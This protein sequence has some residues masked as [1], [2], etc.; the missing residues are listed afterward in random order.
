VLKYEPFLRAVRLCKSHLC[1]IAST[2][3]VRSPNLGQTEFLVVTEVKSAT[4]GFSLGC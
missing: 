1:A 2:T 4:M 3:R